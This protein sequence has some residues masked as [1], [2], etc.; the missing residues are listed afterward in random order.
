MEIRR[1]Q[2]EDRAEVR[3]VNQRAFAQPDEANLVDAL[4]SADAVTLSLVA[5]DGGKVVGHILFSPVAVQSPQGDFSAIGLG[6]MA[7]LPESQ[8]SGVGSQLVRVGLA[9]LARLGHAVVIVLGHPDYYPRFGFVRAS[10]CGIRWELEAPDE[11]FMVLELKPGA[12][13]GRGGIVRYR[14][15]FATVS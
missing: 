2:P 5:V 4:R 8:K 12:L 13:A 3:R 1:E 14:P 11:A 7:V 6:P 15:E 10:T 9:E